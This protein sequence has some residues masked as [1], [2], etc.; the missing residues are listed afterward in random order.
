MYWLYVQYFAKKGPSSQSYVFFISHV[1]MWKLDHKESW[2]TKNWCFWT[3]VLEKTPES[4]LDCQE[5]KPFN[6][7]EISPEY[8]L[9]G[10]MLKLKLQYLSHLMWR[11]DS[12]EKTLKMGKTEGGRR[13]EWQKMRWLDGVTDSM[14]MSLSKLQELVMNW[15]AWY[16]AVHDIAVR[17]DWVTELNWID[18]HIILYLCFLFESIVY[19]L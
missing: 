18:I 14:D 11:T 1:W 12:L 6:S 7:K 2:T 4:P 5:I 17:H 16:A 10:L 19:I 15:E 13:R 3:M 8:S 9:E